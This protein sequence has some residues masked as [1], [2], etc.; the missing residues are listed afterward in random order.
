MW[1]L[2]I[3]AVILVGKA[4]SNFISSDEQEARTR[5]ESKHLEVQKTIEEHR[6]NIERNISAAKSSYDFTFLTDL[7]YSSHRVG[8]AAHKLLQDARTSCNSIKNMINTSK[9]K[10]NELKSILSNSSKEDKKNILIEI[11]AINAFTTSIFAELNTVIN[12]RQSMFDEVK[13]LNLQTREL[14]LAIRDRCGSRGQD[15][16]NRLQERTQLRQK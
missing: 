10:K 2:A 6:K 7:H 12:Q 1:W 4:I 8:D 16:Y 13:R 9:T 5:W 14:K 11:R 3:P 15:W